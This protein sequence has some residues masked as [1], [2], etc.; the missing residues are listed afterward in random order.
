[1]TSPIKKRLALKNIHDKCIKK[2]LTKLIVT[3]PPKPPA[4]I[5]EIALE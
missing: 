4:L 3:I 1:M 5:L 2:I